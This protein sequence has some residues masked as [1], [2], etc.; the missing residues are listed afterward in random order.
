VRWRRVVCDEAHCIK[1]RASNT[2]KAVFALTS[3]YKW[4]LS[5]TPLQ[6]GEGPGCEGARGQQQ[7][8]QQQHHFKS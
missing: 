8:Q 1:D 3:K 4:A 2:A 5:G 7:Q 6:V